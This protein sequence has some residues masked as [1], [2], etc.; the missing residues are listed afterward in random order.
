MIEIAG[1]RLERLVVVQDVGSGLGRAELE[2]ALERSKASYGSVRGVF[3]E[4]QAAEERLFE[5]RAAHLQRMRGW[6][7][8]L[9]A[10][11]V[12][13]GLAGGVAAGLMFGRHVARR[14]ELLTLSA[15]R[16][17]G[18]E[19]LE[20]PDPGRDEIG[21]CSRALSEADHLLTRRETELRDT[22][23]F[24]ERLIETSPTVVFR[25]DPRTLQVTYVSP[26]V[27][28]ILGYTADEIL[29]QPNFW[30]DHIHPEDRQEVYDRDH[31]AFAAGETQLEL[32]YRFQHKD[33]GYRWLDSFARIDYS[34]GQP[35]DFVGHRLDITDRKRA[36]QSLR[37]REANLD[38][39]NRE[40]EAFS[41]SVSHDLRAP[42][43][44]IDGFS[45]A[46]MEDYAGQLDDQA[47]SYLQRVR[48]ATQRMG[49]LID[50]L[51]NLSRV[52]RSPLQR[53]E[54]NLSAAADAIVR[55]L[56]QATPA[57]VVDVAIEPDLK[58]RM[59]PQPDP[60]RAGEPVR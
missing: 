44:S 42:L 11:A 16:L 21:A 17:A 51:L 12:A 4:M 45:Q 39:A 52:T 57:R 35:H 29:S 20:P 34:E 1:E 50:D 19:P 5:P 8:G 26:N 15:G 30:M 6:L 2:R 22:Q 14:I 49:Q 9:I 58:R 18:R 27:A 7:Y 60:R 3:A 24:L 33:G 54:V 59:R 38:A 13:A 25:Q 40:L 32:E 36:E 47:R 28:R 43:R 10:G 23:R 46:L 41:Y 53:S 55:D 31:Q 37:E 56:R 48:A